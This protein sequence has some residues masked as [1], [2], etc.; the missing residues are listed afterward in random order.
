MWIF[1]GE[2]RSAIEAGSAVRSVDGCRLL[3]LVM[4]GTRQERWNDLNGKR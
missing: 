1:L 2:K 4:G 3:V